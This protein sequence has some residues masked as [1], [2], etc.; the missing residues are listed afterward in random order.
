M[1]KWSR[2]MSIDPAIMQQQLR[3]MNTAGAAPGGKLAGMNYAQ[4]NPTFANEQP[5]VPLGGGPSAAA[6]FLESLKHA[7]KDS[8]TTNS[9]T[10]NA[11]Q[12]LPPPAAPAPEM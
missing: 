2:R 9:F 5:A 8:F 7:R 12:A 10:S 4:S 3:S 11:S 1:V 6:P